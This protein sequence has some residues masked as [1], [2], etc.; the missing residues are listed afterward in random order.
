MITGPSQTAKTPHDC[1]SQTREETPD[2]R[3]LEGI[4][5]VPVADG[6]ST[7]DV[8][9][10]DY[11]DGNSPSEK[12]IQGLGV[13]ETPT[14]LV[15]SKKTPKYI[16]R[17][18]ARN[19]GQGYF[20]SKG[21]FNKEKEFTYQNCSC[22]NK[23]KTVSSEKRQNIFD[24]YWGMQNWHAQSNFIAQTVTLTVPERSYVTNSRK[25]H[26]RTYRIDGVK[27]CKSVYLNT[28][29][30]SHRRVDFCLNNKSKQCMCTPDKRGRSTPNKTSEIK[31]VAVKAFLESVPKFRSHYST[32]DRKYFPANLTRIKLFKSYATNMQPERKVSY[33]VFCKIL[34]EFNVGIYRPKTDTCQVCDALS[35]KLKCADAENKSRLEDEIII[36]H[37]RASAART[38][39]QNATQDAKTNKN[40]LVFT[41]DMEKVQ[42]LPAMN[43]SVVFYKRQLSVYNVGI[44]RCHDNQAFMALWTE[45]EAKRGSQEV[46]SSILAFL[47]TQNV[48]NQRV[49]SFSDSCGGQNRNKLVI[50]FI[51]WACENLQISEWEHRY[52]ETGHSYLPNDRDFGQIEK[53]KK[54]QT[55]YSKEAWF[56]LVRNTQSKNPF[57]VIEMKEHFKNLKEQLNKRK[58]PVKDTDGNKFNFLTLRYFGVTRGSPVVRFQSSAD[59]S[60]VIRRIILP[61]QNP[62]PSFDPCTEEILISKEKWNDLQSLLPYVPPVHHAYYKNL[63][64]E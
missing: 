31:V 12:L 8:H 42:S 64:H 25:K 54:N 32:S 7:N 59:E 35:I 51:Q 45:D 30:I 27:V 37:N 29:S 40:L 49:K 6:S 21:K 43:T 53:K 62:L 47:K 23:C 10:S 46:C 9:I 52:M 11:Q 50:N 39:L 20:T 3:Q 57:Q 33:P 19:S 13:S 18:T 4:F 48:T 41:F 24:L 14:K 55:I 44:N 17:K 38:D 1:T 58:F 22:K 16:E 2:E 28:L 5:Q 15:K 61:L 63:K 34:R 36:H 26:T 56:D 60:G